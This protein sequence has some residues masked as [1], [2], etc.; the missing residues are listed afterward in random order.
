MD[1]NQVLD[2]V[3]NEDTPSTSTSTSSSS[4]PQQQH[5]IDSRDIGDGIDINIDIDP[6]TLQQIKELNMDAITL[7]DREN[8][9]EQAIQI[10][11]DAIK[12]SP[13]YAAT[14]NNRAQV[15][16]LMKEYQSAMKDLNQSI[17]Y[18]GRHDI[19]TCKQSYI[20]RGM[21]NQLM[22]DSHSALYDFQIAAKL[23]STFARR[24]SVR[25]NP[26]SALCN[27]YLTDMLNQ[28]CATSK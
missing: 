23:G 5:Q 11:T 17:E 15:Y 26:Y 20:Q 24:E 19:N 16:T 14:Y 10:L 18:S 28:Q 4:T 25:L 9:Y 8:G 21:L 6:R 22:G 27:Q 2:M 1:D 3:F 7:C 12:L 13:L